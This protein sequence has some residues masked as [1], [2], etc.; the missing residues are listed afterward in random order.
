[1]L[2]KGI[3]LVLDFLNLLLLEHGLKNA[4]VVTCIT[5]CISSFNHMGSVW[6]LWVSLAHSSC[7]WTDLGGFKNIPLWKACVRILHW[8]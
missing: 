5:N 4:E 6:C 3:L 8:V 2:N 1:M 7:V